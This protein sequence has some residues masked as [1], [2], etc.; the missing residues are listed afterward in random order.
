MITLV[1]LFEGQ[2]KSKNTSESVKYAIL[3]ETERRKLYVCEYSN[4]FTLMELILNNPSLQNLVVYRTQQIPPS[5]AQLYS[6]YNSLF[7]Q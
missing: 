1:E 3:L 2:S 4:L 6:I 7:S 5:E